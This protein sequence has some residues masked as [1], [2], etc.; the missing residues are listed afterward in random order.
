MDKLLPCPFCGG[1]A[2]LRYDGGNDRYPQSWD[3]MCDVCRVA[4]PES[5]GSSTREVDTGLDELAMSVLINAW[6]R[7]AQPE[8][9]Q[10]E[11]KPSPTGRGREEHEAGRNGVNYSSPIIMIINSLQNKLKIPC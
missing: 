9:A 8:V 3:V 11:P 4:F 2:A 1:K 10:A 5:Y 6:N 7:R